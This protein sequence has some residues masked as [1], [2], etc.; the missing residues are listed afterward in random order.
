M[1][2]LSE[3]FRAPLPYLATADAW[4]LRGLM[5]PNLLL[6]RVENAEVLPGPLRKP[7]AGPCIFAFNHNNSFE[8]LFVPVLLMFLLGGR[9][10]SFVVDWMF[11]CLPLLGR[12]MRRIDPVFVHTKRSTIPMLEKRRPVGSK[13]VVEQCM[14][15]LAAGRSIGIFPEGTRNGNPFHL[16]RARSGIGRLA[17]LSGVPVIPV[18]ISFTASPRLGRAPLVGRMVV[19]FGEEILFDDMATRYRSLVASGRQQAANRL[20]A[21]ASA[22]VMGAIGRL[23]GKSCHEQ[24]PERYDNQSTTEVICPVSPS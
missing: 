12:L 7:A 23:C 13:P 18:G 19:R 11:G 3:L 4:L 16:K 24:S 10:V 15:R 1:I 8:A 17:L 5:L 6:A 9:R 21:H 2:S 22:M 14:Q 20:A